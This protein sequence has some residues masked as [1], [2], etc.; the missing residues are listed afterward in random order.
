[1]KPASERAKEW[2]GQ[3]ELEGA[4]GLIAHV[5]RASLHHPALFLLGAT[6]LFAGSA[7]LTVR[8]FGDIRSSFQELLP[9]DMPSVRQID[10]LSRRVGGDGSVLVL[11][12]S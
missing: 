3:P 1:L 7:V 9:A 8:L 5:T 12:Q 11:V 2:S 4:P 6:L 10:E